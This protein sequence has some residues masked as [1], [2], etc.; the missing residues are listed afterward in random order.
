MLDSVVPH[1][2]SSGPNFLTYIDEEELLNN[3]DCPLLSEIPP[4][5]QK[6]S[7]RELSSYGK[8]EYIDKEWTLTKSGQ[9]SDL[10][11]RVSD[12][13]ED[14]RIRS[15]FHIDG[16]PLSLEKRL[17]EEYD[18]MMKNILEDSNVEEELKRFLRA[19]VESGADGYGYGRSIIA[20]AIESAV[21][22][23]APQKLAVLNECFA[24]QVETHRGLVAEVAR[25]AESLRM[26]PELSDLLNHSDERT[27]RKIALL[28]WGT[29]AKEDRLSSKVSMTT[30]A[31]FDHLGDALPARFPSATNVLQIFDENYTEEELEGGRSE[32]EA[33]L[34]SLL[35]YSIAG[36]L[37]FGL[38]NFYA[39]LYTW[40][41]LRKLILSIHK[42]KGLSSG[43][44][45]LASIFYNPLVESSGELPSDI[46]LF[47]IGS[48]LLG[49][50]KSWCSAADSS[51]RI[52]SERCMQCGQAIAVAAGI[53]NMMEGKEIDSV[54]VHI[55]AAFAKDM[56]DEHFKLDQRIGAALSRQIVT[57]PHINAFASSG[58]K[59]SDIFFQYSRRYDE[60]NMQQYSLRAGCVFSRGKT[61]QECIGHLVTFCGNDLARTR[62]AIR[63]FITHETILRAM[64]DQ[65]PRASE[66]AKPWVA[67]ERV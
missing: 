13:P 34:L 60:A 30:S 44:T 27:V 41:Q 66:I 1:V 37:V 29:G 20:Q 25:I 17:H 2:K 12:Y 28:N 16:S 43:F 64:L 18:T 54:H 63:R 33:Y 39:K 62:G 6:D 56:S 24:Y 52:S 7:V 40:P 22:W 51:G 58:L 11:D 32:F 36:E 10:L 53:G 15:L 23:A 19:I 31:G 21:A 9:S 3:S 26:H 55:D 61:L 35:D 46:V 65:C 42:M 8:F 4:H 14:V 45:E 48:V 57:P 38:L 5:H 67:V 49:V 59:H 50:I 47:R